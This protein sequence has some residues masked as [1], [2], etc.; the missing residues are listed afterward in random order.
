MRPYK[1]SGFKRSF[2]LIFIAAAVVAVGSVWYWNLITERLAQ[3]ARVSI[4]AGSRELAL[5]FDRLLGAQLQV[6]ASI[7]VSLEQSPL[8]QQPARLTEYLNRQNKRNVFTLTGFQFTDGKALFS[9]GAVLRHFLSKAEVEEAFEHSRY[10][11][12]RKKNPFDDSAMLVFAIPL[13]RDG[14]RLG[15][16]FGVQAVDA[17]ETAL[18]GATLPDGGLSFIIKPDGNVVMGYPQ[19]AYQNIFNLGTQA[20]F[21]GDLSAEKLHQDMQNGR[22]GLTGYTLNGSHRF[23]SYYPLGYNGWYALSVLPT[24]SMAEKAQ[25]LMLMSLV[26]CFS[27]IGVLGILL[28]F[29]LRMQYQNSRALF[30]LGFVDPLTGA[31]NLNAFRL[32]FPKAADSFRARGVPFALTVINVNSFKAVND[33]Y[34]FEVGDQILRQVAQ[35]LQGALEEGELFCRS[36]ADVFLLLLACPD[37]AQLEQRVDRLA[38]QAGRFC[39]AGGED[40]LPMSL[41]CGMYLVDEEVPFYI[42]MDR[43]NLAWAAAKQRAGRTCAF[44]DEADR[45]QI[46]TEK[47]IESSMDQALEKGEFQ[48]YLQPK[49]DFKTGK[50]KSAE[51]LVRWKHP[52][53][54]LI[55]PDSF[56]PVFEKNGFVLKLDQFILQQ[57]AALLK[58]WKE[59]GLEQVPVGVNF[60]RLHLDDPHFIDTLVQTVDRAGVEHR[61]LEVELTESVVFGHVERM[62]QVIDG[63]HEK[64]FSVAMD[65]FGSGYSSLNVL[66]NLYFDCVKFDKE[67]LASGEGNPRM[68]QIIAGAV[69]MIKELSCTIVAEGVE[70]QEQSDFLSG[71]GCDLA[72]GYFFSKPLPAAEFTQRLKKNQSRT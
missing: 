34:G 20:R 67:F 62:K 11:S 46:V 66:K 43:A 26:L 12:E 38:L 6:L 56:I 21:D 2:G 45:R 61:L 57:T 3:D 35:A 53:R 55:P 19:V 25:S 71:I 72:Q 13:R 51:A 14:E 47:R 30:R 23:S 10:V 44:Y 18:A 4:V 29:I 49:C 24:A 63:L 60:S 64:G 37:R 40:C 54:G 31:D 8:L 33:I 50:I 22:S 9:N 28:I 68:R 52:V 5:D 27:I 36:G 58:Q 7:G 59:Q 16:V 41:T 48:L 17:Y 1:I 70:T 69:K 15:V 65:D 42:M 32:K 39:R